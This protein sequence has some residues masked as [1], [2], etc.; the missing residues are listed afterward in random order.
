VLVGQNIKRYLQEKK[1]T[2]CLLIHGEKYK[3]IGIVG[4]KGKKHYGIQE[5]LCLNFITN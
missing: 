4:F 5:F 1:R 3:V 2:Q